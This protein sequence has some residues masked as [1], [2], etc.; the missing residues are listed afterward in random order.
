MFQGKHKLFLSGVGFMA[1]LLAIAPMCL[2]S[3]NA[4]PYLRDGV[5]ARSIGLG[6][7]FTAIADDAT[8]TIWNPAGLPAT[9][10]LDFTLSRVPMPLEGNKNFMAIVKGLGENSS[11]G[12]SW[13]NVGVDDIREVSEDNGITGRRFNYDSNALALSFGHALESFNLGASVRVL[14]DAV[15]LDAFDG[16]TSFGGVDVGMLARP[17]TSLSYGLAV[18][19]I[20]GTVG[21]ESVP[22]IVG[23]GVAYHM[24]QGHRATVAVDI[25]H[26]IGILDESPT[27]VRMGTEYR[28][29]RTFAVRGGTQVSKD[30]QALFVGFGFD[31]GALQLDY[32]LKAGER[33]TRS[34][35]DAGETHYISLSYGY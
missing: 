31:V 24:L 20:G 4:A 19:N 9:E 30:R 27:S 3:G 25:E 6:G 1:L 12:F 2:A 29:A 11:I 5:G 34:L 16:V 13:M 33:A 35:Q 18:R 28:I 26:E 17:G 7:A 14:S 32:A 8:S 15:G 22:I 23:A 10:T 21:D